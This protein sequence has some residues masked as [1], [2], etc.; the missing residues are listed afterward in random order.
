MSTTKQTQD[1]WELVTP[2]SKS[3]LDFSFSTTSSSND[4]DFIGIAADLLIPGKG[5]PNKDQ[6]ILISRK[7][8]KIIFVGY[9]SRIPPEHYNVH[10]QPV[11]V[12][13][14]GMWECHA[15]F[16]GASPL[17]PIDSE[18]LLMTNA[19]EAGARCARSIK[20]TLYAGFTSAVELGGYAT[21]LR[22]VVEEGS[23]LGPTLYGAGGAISMTA[24]HGDVF[25][26]GRI[27]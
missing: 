11:P 15:H 3:P 19:A 26:Y 4:D 8:G 25:E 14:P 16:M 22:K 13:M 20:D 27:Q 24:G 7:T 1:D 21:E 23:I 10:L 12:I 6:A 5:K 9:A 17:R 18:N 2:S